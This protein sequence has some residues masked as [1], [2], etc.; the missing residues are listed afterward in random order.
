MQM[1]DKLLEIDRIP[2]LTLILEGV[3]FQT[4]IL[5][6]CL[7]GF[8]L[9]LLLIKSLQSRVYS[10]LI[11]VKAGRSKMAQILKP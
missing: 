10:L 3:D 11:D 5:A 6:F 7:W 8:S 9:C 2:E 4:I 1:I